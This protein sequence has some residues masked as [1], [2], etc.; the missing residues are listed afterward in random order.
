M[1]PCDLGH[2]DVVQL[3]LD[4]SDSN[5]ELNAR[6]NDG[7]TAF[8]FACY[9]RRNDVVKLFL[10][11]SERID[12]NARTK[13]G[14]TA[15]MWACKCGHKDVVQLLLEHSK[16]VDITIPEDF[17]LSQEIR[18]L[19]NKHQRSHKYNYLSNKGLLRRY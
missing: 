13:N 19:I 12:L 14:R 11:H 16:D 18:Y 3:F 10:D 5:I 9:C 7:W 15:F 17:Y 4:H 2:K 8:M 6:D 1:V